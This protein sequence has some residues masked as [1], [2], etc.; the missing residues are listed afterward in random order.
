[1]ADP[2]QGA[3][4]GGSNWMGSTCI[5]ATQSDCAGIGGS[6]SGDGTSCPMVSCN[7]AQVSCTATG[8]EEQCR[9]VGDSIC[10]GSSC[11][12]KVCTNP[13]AVPATS[14]GWAALLIVGLATISMLTVG[15]Y[16]AGRLDLKGTKALFR[17]AEGRKSCVFEQGAPRQT[18]VSSV[19]IDSRV[20]FQRRPVV[21]ESS[22]RCA[23]CRGL[24]DPARPH[25][26]HPAVDSIH[27]SAGSSSSALAR[28]F[29]TV[30]REL[31]RAARTRP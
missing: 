15:K 2:P 19:N 29:A 24:E 17:N 31:L 20:F 1:V 6:Y 5:L 3:C 25:R 18:H 16:R 22:R 4:A 10:S 14:P 26:H 12:T 11:P 28:V 23:S 30:L 27:A 8:T 7:V 9:A 13:P 21:G